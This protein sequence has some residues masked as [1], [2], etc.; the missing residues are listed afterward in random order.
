[1]MIFHLHEQYAHQMK[2]EIILNSY[3]LQKS[4]IIYEIFW[5]KL[6]F[7]K[8]FFQFSKEKKILIA[9]FLKI[10]F[11]NP[12][13]FFLTMILNTKNGNYMEVWQSWRHPERSGKQS[14]LLRA[15][16]TPPTLF[17]VKEAYGPALIT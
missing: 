14:K 8:N 13:I 11:Y 12:P 4:A 9:N 6:D 16:S 1:M 17:R 3:L 5:K 15:D 2:A 10:F 7:K